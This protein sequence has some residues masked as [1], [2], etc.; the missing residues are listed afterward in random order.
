M[1][2]DTVW[3][4]SG[5]LSFVICFRSPLRRLL[6]VEQLVAVGVELIEDPAGAEE[7]VPNQIAVIVTVHPLEPDRPGELPPLKGGRL[8]RW[9]IDRAKKLVG[10]ADEFDMKMPHRLIL[11]DAGTAVAFQCG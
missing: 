7:L 11:P 10:A 8:P 4:V 1:T 6:R 3:S 2:N 5:H 9:L